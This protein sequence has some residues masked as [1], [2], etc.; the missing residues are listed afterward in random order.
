MV[1]IGDVLFD[2]AGYFF[3]RETSCFLMGGG[4]PRAA[5][6]VQSRYLRVN[7]DVKMRRQARE[8]QIS[9]VRMCF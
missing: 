9:K 1:T 6:E 2:A 8:Y 5:V 3:L 4:S 7:E